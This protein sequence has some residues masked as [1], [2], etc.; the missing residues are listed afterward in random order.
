MKAWLG[1]A[2]INGGLAV[3]AGAFAAHG[4]KGWLDAQA[5]EVFETGA[6]YHM[7]HALAMGLAALAARGRGSAVRQ[8]GGGAV[9]GGHHPVF[10]LALS[11]GPDRRPEHGI[12]HPIR[13]RGISGGLGG[14]GDGGVETGSVMKKILCLV[15]CLAAPDRARL[16]P[17]ASAEIAAGRPRP[18]K[19]PR[20]VVLTFSEALEPAFS[21]ALLMDQSG[22]NFSAAPTKVNGPVMTLTPGRLLPGRYRVVWHSVGA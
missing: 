8:G 3:L 6:R 11:F 14:F 4:L 16:G 19:S 21:G 22:R 10:R 15:C 20:H 7:Y 12:C 18:V 2:A 5:L 17:C 13:R 9:P 1:I